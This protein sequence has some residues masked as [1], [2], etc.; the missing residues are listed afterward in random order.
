M[1]D[2]LIRAIKQSSM[3][4]PSGEYYRDGVRFGFNAAI[5]GPLLITK[6]QPLLEKQDLEENFLR[7]LTQL[8][9]ET[10]ARIKSQIC[11][12]PLRRQ[13]SAEAETQKLN[14]LHTKYGFKPTSVNEMI[15]TPSTPE[16][17]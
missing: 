8:A 17:A 2:D 16:R 12:M 4:L 5:K 6:I 13:F 7:W 9:D 3:E 10:E 1:K 15:R 11:A 14:D